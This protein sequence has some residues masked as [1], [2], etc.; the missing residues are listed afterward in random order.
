MRLQPVGQTQGQSHSEC[1]R[2]ALPRMDPPSLR[3]PCVLKS[4][5]T[6]TF[7]SESW[8]WGTVCKANIAGPK[9][10]LEDYLRVRRSTYGSVSCETGRDE[11]LTGCP[12]LCGTP[13]RLGSGYKPLTLTL[14]APDENL[15]QRYT[16]CTRQLSRRGCCETTRMHPASSK[17][18][19]RARSLEVP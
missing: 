16:I 5:T 11:V 4:Q 12:T 8:S 19:K 10:S 13:H 2:L 7:Q 17:D 14:M 9:D 6:D 3:C 18:L 1:L 15:A